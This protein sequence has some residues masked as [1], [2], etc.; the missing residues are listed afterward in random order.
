MISILMPH[1]LLFIQD[2]VCVF[3]PF[4]SSRIM[5]IIKCFPGSLLIRH[6]KVLIILPS[7]TLGVSFAPWKLFLVV[8]EGPVFSVG[9]VLEILVPI[10]MLFK[11]GPFFLV[12][13]WYE[14][15]PNHFIDSRP[16]GRVASLAAVVVSVRASLCLHHFSPRSRFMF[17]IIIIVICM[18]TR[19]RLLSFD[20][21]SGHGLSSSF[22][23]V[24]DF[25]LRIKP[26]S[27]IKSGI[28]IDI[29][30]LIKHFFSVPT[31][32]SP[33]KDV[34]VFRAP[35]SWPPPPKIVNSVIKSVA[36]GSIS[37]ISH[38][39]IEVSMSPRLNKSS[40]SGCLL[41]LGSDKL[42]SLISCGFVV[43]A[44]DAS[45]GRGC[46]TIILN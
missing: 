30:V 34:I 27:T 12:I 28:I 1:S 26:M 35:I 16:D 2:S 23:F 8:A 15:V 37:W 45:S 32:P 5:S 4:W 43:S 18:I 9:E 17:I 11:S 42:L 7:K 3:A 33:L 6:I 39:R 22:F 20:I 38:F 13:S 29:F 31:A 14:I 40:A 44:H 21:C 46:S 41:A 19:S 24:F 25:M 10:L 36:V